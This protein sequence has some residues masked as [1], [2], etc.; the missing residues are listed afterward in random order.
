MNN[1][2][3][4]TEHDIY[5]FKEGRH[6]RL[7]DKLGS[8]IAEHQGVRGTYFAVWAPN[9]KSISVI[10]DFNN[11]DKNANAMNVRWD[12]SG[13]WEIFLPNVGQGAEYKYHIIS[14]FD[15]YE[16]DK[17]DPFAFCSQMP[18]NTAS[19]VWDLNY[20]WSNTS[21]KPK[22][23]KKSPMSIYEVHAGSW[24]RAPIAPEKILTINE[25]S[26]QLTNYVWEMGFTHIEFM[27]I[28]EHPFYGSWGYQTTGYFS[29]SRRYGTPQDLMGFID[30]LHKN[31]IGVIF[32]WVPSHFPSDEFGLVYFD[33]THLYE[34][35][36]PRK[37]FHPD[38]KS[39][40][41]NYSRNE[42]RSFLISSAMFWLDKYRID[43][44]RVDAVASMLYL[45]YSRKP[46]EWVPNEQGGRENLDAIHFLRS[47]NNWVHKEFMDS[48]TIAEESTAWPMVTKPPEVGGLGFNL[49][50][51]MGWMHDTLEY[52]QQ[53][54]I[55]RK[56]HHGNLT[57]SLLYAFSEN[58]I[59]PLSHDEV[60]YGK[61]SLL[62]KMP[63]DE[64]QKFAN[65]RLLLGYM[66]THPGR[67]LL[68]M[69]NELGE[70]SEWNH[71]KS[72]N[73][74]IL[75]NDLNAG[76]NNFVKDLNSF[77]RNEPAVYENDSEGQSFKWIDINDIEK[78]IISF[79]RF[80][81]ARKS[82][83]VVCNF[84]PVPRYN[85]KVGVPAGGVWKEII[86]S[87]AKDYAGSGQ[88]NMG[89]VQAA[90]ISFYGKFDHSLSITLPPLGIVIFKKE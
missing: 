57:F 84:T 70:Y 43:G 87:D 48:I 50:W 1:F 25:I 5:L 8:H 35:S 85:Y 59:L 20:E 32:D 44:L 39:C 52:F 63:G 60:V 27:P 71:D 38:W 30:T 26:K 68:F 65:L 78:S 90:P 12:Q 15:N 77:Y 56:Y 24:R 29:P 88:G 11:W 75:N 21:Y 62:Q 64:W 66:Y 67:K 14:Q 28:M 45:D 53:E 58:Y 33:G 13:I 7:Y 16:V 19:A 55:N 82:I 9:A 22:D 61:G 4:I 3:L 17:A 69:G 81:K 23:W 72:L 54:P 34:H 18:P 36:D 40:I 74:H 89:M 31:N 73:W 49:K 80:D 6:F 37:G 83:A 76:L 86:N 10:G 2:S 51:N 47:F 41:F 42:V 46:G 79:L